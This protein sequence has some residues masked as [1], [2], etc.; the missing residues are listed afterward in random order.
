MW[1]RFFERAL[2][3]KRDELTPLSKRL[4]Q[5]VSFGAELEASFPLD[6]EG[7]R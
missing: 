4:C 2:A 5:I 1:R 7:Q 6:R 3:K